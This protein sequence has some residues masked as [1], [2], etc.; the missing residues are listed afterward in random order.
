MVTKTFCSL[1]QKKHLP[2]IQT[3]ALYADISTVYQTS[4][5]LDYFNS[6][7]LRTCDCPFQL[8]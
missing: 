8:M 5:G 3:D 6:S 2:L 4:E 7:I 1:K